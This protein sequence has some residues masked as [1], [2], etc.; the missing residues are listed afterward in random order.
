MTQL[1]MDLILVVCLKDFHVR[2]HWLSLLGNLESPRFAVGGING[3]QLSVEFVG[4]LTDAENKITDLFAVRPNLGVILVSD[5]LIHPGDDWRPE[6]RATCAAKGLREQFATKLYVSLAVDRL[7][8]SIPDIDLILP[9]DCDV[10]KLMSGIQLLL[11]RLQYYALPKKRSRPA[12][13]EV[14]GLKNQNELRE[15]FRLR[16]RTYQV[17]GYLGEDAFDNKTQ[18]EVDWC[19]LSSNQYGAFVDDEGGER[20]LIATARLIMTRLCDPRYPFWTA[21]VVRSNPSLRKSQARQQEL[22]AGF[23]LPIFLTLPLNEQMRQAAM[24]THPW[25]ELSRVIVAPAWRGLGISTDLV[26][27]AIHDADE[28]KVEAVLLECLDLHMNMYKNLGFSVL[29]LRGEV[30]QVGKTMLGM[31]RQHPAINVPNVVAHVTNSHLPIPN[32]CAI[33]REGVS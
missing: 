25:A 20:K 9:T 3:T 13:I 32:E 7:T 22:L 17:M 30:L 11:E 23:K 27:L 28:R 14:R 24:A 19:D 18:M 26:K 16:Y 5:G 21:A 31:Q 29:D 8:K 2:A 12:R 4:N 15:A 10:E 33:S 6:W 1:Q